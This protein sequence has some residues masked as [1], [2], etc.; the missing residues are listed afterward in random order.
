MHWHHIVRSCGL[1][2]FTPTS[3]MS[4]W[5]GVIV[6]TKYQHCYTT[7]FAVSDYNVHCGCA[8]HAR[9]LLLSA[10]TT[11]SASSTL[12][13]LLSGCIL[14]KYKYKSFPSLTTH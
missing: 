9:C 4:V 12:A 13:T 3:Q 6:L 2:A 5:W 11:E 10:A 8:T 7:T 1:A 14:Y